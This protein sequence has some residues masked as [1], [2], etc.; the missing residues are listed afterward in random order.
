MWAKPRAGY[1]RTDSR[2]RGNDGRT[3]FF[4]LIVLALCW[5]LPAAAQAASK[6]DW[7]SVIQQAE[8]AIVSIEVDAPRAFDTEWNFSGEATGF[9]VDAKRGIILTNRHVVQ[10]GPVVASAV[11]QDHEEVELTPLYRDPVH[12]FGFFHYDPSK[13]KYIHPHALELAP[14]EARIGREIRIIGNDAGEQLSILA[15]TLARIDRNAPYYGSSGYNDFNTF[16]FQA[17]SGTSGGSSG[18]PVIDSDG[19]VIAMNAGGETN[20]SSSYFLPLDRIVPALE[21]IQAGER[22]PRGTLETVFLHENYNDLELLGLDP[23]TARA[24]RR[25]AP[26]ASGLLVVNDV[27]PGGPAAGKLRPGDILVRAGGKLIVNFNTLSS[28][29]DGSV[30][31]TLKLDV[32]RGGKPLSVRVRVSDLHAIT[33]TSYLEFGGAVLN[34]LSYEMARN[35]NKPIRGVFVADPGFVF[36]TA[37]IARGAV[38]T[39]LDGTPVATLDEFQKRLETLAHGAQVSVR[40]YD[41]ENPNEP[42]SAQITLDGHWFP[43]ERCHSDSRSGQWPCTV[44]PPPRPAKALKPVTVSYPDYRDTRK[45]ALARSLV[46]IQFDMPYRIEGVQQTHYVGT[47]LVI[48]AQ[49]GLVIVDRNTV[50]VSMGMLRLTFAGSVTIPAVVSYIDPLHNLAVLHY[51][52]ALLGKTPVAAA[53]F[54]NGNLHAGDPV[55]VVGFNDNQTLISQATAVANVEPLQLPLSVTLRF[56]DRNLDTIRVVNAP[57]MIEGVLADKAGHVIAL[58][59]SFAYQ[60]GRDVQQTTLGVPLWVV[61][62]TIARVEK[63]EHPT[64]R[65]LETEFWPLP[66]ADAR[67]R[68]LPADWASR[69]ETDDRP[70]Q[71]LSITR[72]T[73]GGPADGKLRNGDLLLAIDGQPVHDFEQL[74][75]LSQRDT[76]ALT[77]LRDRKVIHVKLATARLGS[78]ALNRV[79]IW[80]GTILQRPPAALAAQRHQPRSG[81]WVAY[82][83][84]GSPASRYGLTPGDRIVAVN[85]KPTPNLDAFLAA[86]NGIAKGEPIRLRTI[87]P[88]GRPSLVAMR[89]DPEYWPTYELRRID[90][91]WVR[92]ALH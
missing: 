92:R 73:A 18:S 26:S 41:P 5:S 69:F 58:W 40:Y 22:V 8:P 79:V 21:R 57:G 29:L 32:E 20:T 84:Y 64:V 77:V 14:A 1:V 39:R 65:S 74:A 63:S 17:D 46:Y 59:S 16:Y 45:R 82:F 53:H 67:D 10:P 9:V 56:R 6:A 60:S 12:D 55:W 52:P 15:G 11:F 13:L 7:A 48:D 30:G 76:A 25:E 89:L 81:V 66:L 51:D 31:R 83:N 33:P 35:L 71:V 75:A 72:V 88:N 24:V 38:I 19:R 61:R 70:R 28:L 44:L 80:G 68:G 47:G 49:K 4:P 36:S 23:A 54:G 34:N 27:I 42:Q 50:P 43:A 2:I 78:G 85:G 86:A 37:G 90:G 91:H 3:L 87:D 62:A